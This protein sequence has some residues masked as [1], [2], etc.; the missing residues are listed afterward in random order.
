MK[1][2]I[3]FEEVWTEIFFDELSHIICLGVDSQ[4]LN[5]KK[6]VFS[7]MNIFKIF[8]ESLPES[9]PEGIHWQGSRS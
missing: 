5:L 9:C 2:S 7:K 4:S 1:V 3:L 8:F 6:N